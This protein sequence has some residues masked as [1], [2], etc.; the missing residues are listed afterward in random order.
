ML[1]TITIEIFHMSNW[2]AWNDD[3]VESNKAAYTRNPLWKYLNIFNIIEP[4][5]PLSDQ[6]SMVLAFII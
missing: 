4:T 3:F 5:V 1:I 2:D 6:G